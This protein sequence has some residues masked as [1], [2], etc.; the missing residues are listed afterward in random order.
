MVERLDQDGE[1]LAELARVMTSRPCWRSA[2]RLYRLLSM[3]CMTRIS[4]AMPHAS[5]VRP[6]PSDVP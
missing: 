1:Q 5:C 6:V 3:G 2:T 4:F